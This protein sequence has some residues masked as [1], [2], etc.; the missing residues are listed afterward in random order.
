MLAR[1]GFVV[2]NY[3]MVGY[4]DTKQT[5]HAFGEPLWNWGPLGLQLWNSIRAVDYLVSLED[6]DGGG[7]GRRGRRAGGRRRFC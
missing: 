5:P 6:V 2:L 3:D 1:M 7:L 4:N